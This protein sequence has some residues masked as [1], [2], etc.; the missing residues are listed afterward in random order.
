[1]A[2]A[3]TA[4]STLGL[5]EAALETFPPAFLDGMTALGR[6]RVLG[7]TG[8]NA[9]AQWWW[10][11]TGWRAD[12]VLLAYGKSTEAVAALVARVESAC[13]APQ[14]I[15]HRIAL[16]RI[17]EARGDRKEPFGFVDGT[18]QPVIRGTYR[19]LRNADPIHLVEPGEFIIGYPD[20]RGNLPPAPHLDAV[21]DPHNRLPIAADCDGFSRTI[22][23]A[24]RDVARNGSFLVVRQLEQEIERFH[25][26]CEAEAQRLQGR[27]E[28]PYRITPDFIGAKLV[29]RWADGSSLVR[30]PYESETA[31][32]RS[33]AP[34]L[35]PR[36]TAR[37][38]STPETGTPILSATTP[39]PT[40]VDAKPALRSSEDNDFLYGTEDPEALRCPFGAHI[41]RAN[42][43]DSLVPGSSEQI[44]ITN[45]HRILR[46]GRV[47]APR[48]G[49]RPGLLF[50]CL[51]SDI[52][53]QFEFIQQTWLASPAFHGLE[54]EV[55]P[56]IG[57]GSVGLNGFTVP[58]RDAP[59]RLTPMRQFV[60]M[61]GGGY[62][63]LPG[64]RLL[65][66]LKD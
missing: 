61:R 1:L 64:K 57:D 5:P 14:C 40:V 21:H 17:P 19:G 2:L 49:Q 59:L 16:E 9:A 12:A 32:M 62:F 23:D 15:A 56:L 26:Y 11:N 60:T 31:L 43:R 37:P 7:D 29:G 58:T 25:A 3:P 50:M 38:T 55:D 36:P 8:P 28:Q 52:E 48:D 10:P 39:A 30:F 24:P 27:L 34:V 22:V 13:V 45:R 51:N 33:R 63:F 53:R 66:F 18:S 42:P 65:E 6:E 35:Q 54:G 20:N 41:R 47:Y 46:V 4:L 44:A